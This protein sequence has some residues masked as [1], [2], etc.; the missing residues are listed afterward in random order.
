MGRKRKEPHRDGDVSLGKS[1]G[2]WVASFVNEGTDKRKRARLVKLSEPES[3]A[4]AALATF[5]DARRAIQ[6]QQAEYTIGALWKMWLAEREAD[7]K[8]IDIHNANW[9][10]LAPSFAH[11]NPLLTT[12]ADYRAYAQKRFDMG[13]AP[14]TVHTELIRLRQCL[15]WAHDE[16]KIA[17]A[18]KVWLPMAGKRRERN[19]SPDEAVRLVAAARQGD[20]HIYVFVVLAFSTGGRHTAILD[21]EWSRVDFAAGT[22]NLEV[23]LPPDPMNKSWRKGRAE[24]VMSDLARK[25]LLEAHAGKQSKF[26]V[27]HGGRRLKTVREGFKNAVERAG[28]GWYVPSNNDPS[29]KVFDTDVTPHTIRHTVGS[30]ADNSDIDVRRIAQLLGHRDD[31]TTRKIY[32]HPDAENTRGMVKVIDATFAVLPKLEQKKAKAP[33]EHLIK[34]VS[35]RAAYQHLLDRVLS[36]CLIDETTGCWNWQGAQSNGG[37]GRI[38]VD[39]RLASPHRVVAFC[40][41][42]IEAIFDDENSAVAMHNCDN[43]QCCN[44]RHLSGGRRSDNME[45]NAFKGRHALQQSVAALPENNGD[46]QNKRRISRVKPDAASIIDKDDAQ[47]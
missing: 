5:A 42:A 16:N 30:W 4:R 39:G 26:V 36:K 19:L 1:D 28:L 27:E 22:I 43:P 33:A 10:A 17:K 41:G 13:R 18:P 29:I 12:S 24:M 47:P 37:Y 25:A 6:T 9:K 44:P 7:G 34:H 15:Q 21:L 40:D 11:R 35:R 3:V 46:A 2:W 38:K 20:P 8:R 14:D 31:A 32:L 45:D 23:D